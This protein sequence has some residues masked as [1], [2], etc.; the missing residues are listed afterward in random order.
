MKRP[1]NVS[2]DGKAAFA[3]AKHPSSLETPMLPCGARCRPITSG[4]VAAVCLGVVTFVCSSALA[5]AQVVDSGV[6]FVGAVNAG[7]NASGG[8][9]RKN[10][11]SGQFDL[12]IDDGTTSTDVRR[13][14]RVRAEGLY[15][16]SQ[17]PG[18]DKTVGSE[19]YY[20]EVRGAVDLGEVLGSSRQPD[21]DSG[22]WLY[23]IGS[24]LHTIAF[25][26]DAQR[27][28]GVGVAY[29]VRSAPGL[30]V[31]ADLRH[32]REQF[33]TQEEFSSWALGLRQSYSR[34]WVVGTAAASRTFVFSQAIEAVPAFESR[35]ALQMKGIV[36]LA[37]P[38]VTG[39]SMPITYGVDYMRNTPP[40]F[41]RRFWKTT[42]S[43][44]YAFG[45]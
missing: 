38:I 37:L 24:V 31:S 22:V 8:T 17:A 33:K 34:S 21:A 11:V 32:I 40:G 10:D 18:K 29:D 42:F 14:V 39:W 3:A 1:A 26:L 44:N 2:R 20:L 4:R 28:F 43:L 30:S 36:S 25:D 35:D 23:A 27:A 13:Q 7:V 15:G 12:A 41:K 6:K 5:S 45:S 19:M 9:Q 16:T